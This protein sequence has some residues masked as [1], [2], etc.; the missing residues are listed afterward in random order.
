MNASPLSAESTLPAPVLVV[1][2]EPLIRQRL[3]DV[4]LGLGYTPDVLNF[5]ES[6]AQARACMAEG[7]MALA[8][9]DLGL[10]DGSG[11]D[12]IREWR[13]A[14]PALPILVISAWSTEDAI[15]AALRAGATG[16]GLKERDD[17]E[18]MLS[19]RSAL[20]G[21][22]PIDPFIARRILE[23]LPDTPSSAPP[24]VAVDT[25][26]P[27]PAISVAHEEAPEPDAPPTAGEP[28]T[29]REREILKMVANGLSNREISEHLHLSYYTVETHVK[30]IYRKLCVN[31]R[32]MA[33]HT[34]LTRRD[35]LG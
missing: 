19:I 28:L 9:V 23:L 13:A 10:P 24:T 29:K 34:A 2:D 8:L 32:A 12:L 35:L 3:Q 17:F 30:R 15:L 27:A 11:I 31:T 20:R 7:P 14:D 16:Y 33:V 6:M 21:G 1:E 25:S 18:V 4:L 26:T 22:A 5:A